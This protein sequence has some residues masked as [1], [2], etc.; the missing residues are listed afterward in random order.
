VE[1]FIFPEQALRTPLLAYP[2]QEQPR[3]VELV[4]R[5]HYKPVW[6]GTT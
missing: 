4:H 6:D 3:L 1:T 5:Q 2:T